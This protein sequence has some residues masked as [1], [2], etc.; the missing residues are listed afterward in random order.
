M[1]MVYKQRY[2]KQFCV[3]VCVC[4]GGGGGGGAELLGVAHFYPVFSCFIT[5]A[6][7]FEVLQ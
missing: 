7:V 5:H 4:V 2:R 3:C 6:V 1:Q